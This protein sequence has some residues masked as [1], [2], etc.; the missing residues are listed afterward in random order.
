MIWVQKTK[1]LDIKKALIINW[2]T[3]FYLKLKNESEIGKWCVSVLLS[4][5]PKDNFAD[6]AEL[7]DWLQFRCNYHLFEDLRQVNCLGFQNHKCL[8][9]LHKLLIAIY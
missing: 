1:N 3:L 9:Y 4:R 6:L 2:L 8:Q 5:F 7:K